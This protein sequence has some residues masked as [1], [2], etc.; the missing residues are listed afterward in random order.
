M[1][2]PSFC[3]QCKKDL[4]GAIEK[5]STTVGNFVYLVSR[6][7]ADCN[8]RQC[9]GCKN[10]VCKSCD[11][12]QPLYCCDEGRIVARERAATLAQPNS[13]GPQISDLPS[14]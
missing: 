6:E 2:N 9:G 4:T 3:P 14:S 12:E 8:W 1:F 5:V 7:T 13:Q 11:D 10:V